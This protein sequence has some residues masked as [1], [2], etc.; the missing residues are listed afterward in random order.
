[1][2]AR[3]VPLRSPE[4]GE[5]PCPPTAAERIALVTQLSREAW[6]LAGRPVP[7]YTRGTMP[8]AL[9]TLREQGRD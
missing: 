3:V 4:A 5:P 9:T 8:V 7:S 2:T 6:Q 1:M